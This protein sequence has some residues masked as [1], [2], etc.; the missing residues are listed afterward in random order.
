MQLRTFL[1]LISIIFVSPSYIQGQTAD[2]ITRRYVAFIGGEKKW[3]KIKTLKTSGEYNYGGMKFPFTAYS[4]A[5]NQYKFI[6]PFQGKYYAQA[7]DG[8]N[9]WKIDAFKNETS[10]TMLSGAA[11]L[12]MANEADVELQDVFIDYK[13]KGHQ[14]TLEQK[15]T[16][17]GRIC[18]RIKLTRSGGDS[19]TYCFDEKT[20]ELLM[21][22]AAA[23]NAELQGTILN[24]TYSDYRDIGGIK[25]PFKSVSKSNDQMILEISIEKAEVN[26]T[27]D[28][29][30]FQSP[31]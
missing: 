29:R 17:D 1:L 6:V 9:G 16:I 31:N 19:E 26:E 8:K 2:D 12:A 11:A 24:T 20:S 18:V 3:K 28:D 25:I 13:E 10:P 7:F 30:E 23:K 15:D 27:I 5:P 22:T 4:K 21:K 14:A